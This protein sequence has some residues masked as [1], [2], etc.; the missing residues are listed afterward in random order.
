MESVLS[1]ACYF[2]IF[3]RIRQWKTFGVFAPCHNFSQTKR[4]TKSHR[5]LLWDGNVSLWLRLRNRDPL[6]SAPLLINLWH[7][8]ILV[9]V[10]V[11]KSRF[12]S[13]LQCPSFAHKTLCLSSQVKG[14]IATLVSKADGSSLLCFTY[15]V[16]PLIIHLSYWTKKLSKHRKKDSQTVKT[17]QNYS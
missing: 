12:F 6:H 8:V 3:T 7:N 17:A 10:E 15:G 5:R 11:D 13:Q 2:N 4:E 14:K 16:E 9:C 1:W